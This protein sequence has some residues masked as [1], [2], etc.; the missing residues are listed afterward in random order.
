MNFGWA[1]ND[2]YSIEPTGR[3]FWINEPEPLCRRVFR[4][5]LRLSSGDAE[6]D[7]AKRKCNYDKQ[8]SVHHLTRSRRQ[9]G[10]IKDA[11]WASDTVWLVAGESRNHA[12]TLIVLHL[13][14]KSKTNPPADFRI[15]GRSVMHADATKLGHRHR[16]RIAP[17]AGTIK[18]TL[19]TIQ[20]VR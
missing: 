9:N 13:N 10:V 8:A 4:S 2:H 16:G 15:G 6:F 7:T 12:R 14:W 1:G 5:D 11:I 3:W 19:R 20:S 17:C 18:L